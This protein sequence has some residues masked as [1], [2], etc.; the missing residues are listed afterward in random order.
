VKAP[1]GTCFTSRWYTELHYSSLFFIK[2]TALQM[3][4]YRCEQRQGVDTQLKSLAPRNIAFNQPNWQSTYKCNTDARSR[5]SCCRRKAIRITY[6]E[7]VSVPLVV[8][9]EKR[10]RRIILSSATCLAVPY[11]STL[12]HKQHDFREKVAEYKT[13]VLIFCR[14]F[15]WNIS[16][17]KKNWARYDHKYTLVFM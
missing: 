15:V 7:C 1:H 11:F 17:S 13:S 10:I 12:P 6:P 8:Q 14:N 4:T 2:Q 16:Y 9:H 3:Q 5:N